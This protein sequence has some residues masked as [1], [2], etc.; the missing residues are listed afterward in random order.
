MKK[1]IPIFT[2]FILAI[3]IVAVAWVINS[4]HVSAIKIKS[5]E[6]GIVVR[7]RIGDS[8]APST[9]ISVD[10]DFTELKPCTFDGNN[11][12]DINGNI[13]DDN[14]EYVRTI[15]L[16]MLPENKCKVYGT[17]TSDSELPVKLLVYGNEVTENTYIGTLKTSGQT[18]P[19]LFYIDGEEYTEPGSATLELTLKGE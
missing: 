1:F 13:V 14:P 19:L 2:A 16:Y 12:K 18:I 17:L 4:T 3:S 8:E 11:F 5:A 7:V 10:S 9:E 6:E 15:E